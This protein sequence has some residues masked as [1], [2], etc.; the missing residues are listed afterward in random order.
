MTIVRIRIIFNSIQSG[1]VKSPSSIIHFLQLDNLVVKYS[2]FD[3]E[4]I[5]PPDFYQLYYQSSLPDTC[6]LPVVLSASWTEVYCLLNRTRGRVIILLSDIIIS[7]Y[8]PCLPSIQHL[9]RLTPMA[10]H[11]KVQV[12]LSVNELYISNI[13]LTSH[14]MIYK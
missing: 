11:T 2:N 5:F 13:S 14:R 3:C 6:V 8:L 1:L 4:I 12:I 10:D 7:R 9:G